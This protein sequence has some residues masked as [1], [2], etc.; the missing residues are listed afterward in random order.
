M[1]P[2]ARDVG[3]AGFVAINNDKTDW[4]QTF[5]TSLPDGV[6][7]DVVG[8]SLSNG[9]CTGYWTYVPVPPP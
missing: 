4:V 8:G 7:C 9:Q 6:Y 1:V 5:K 3:S 2:G